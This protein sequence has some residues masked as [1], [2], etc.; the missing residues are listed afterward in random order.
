L[1]FGLIALGAARF[2]VY[3]CATRPPRCAEFLHAAFSM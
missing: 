2:L 1:I 3:A